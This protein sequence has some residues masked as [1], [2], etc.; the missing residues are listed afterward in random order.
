MV[1][2]RIDNCVVNPFKTYKE[3]SYNY[4]LVFTSI[5]YYG[6]E[7]YSNNTEYKSFDELPESIAPK[8]AMFKVLK[9]NEPIAQ[10][11]CKYS[12]G[13]FFIPSV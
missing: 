13:Y 10:F 6:V 4:D 7:I 8:F 9:E 11:G 2:K 5:P 1:F 12:D 3:H